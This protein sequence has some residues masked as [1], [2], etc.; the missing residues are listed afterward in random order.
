M[1]TEQRLAACRS[2]VAL[3]H[4]ALSEIVGDHGEALPEALRERAQ[5]ALDACEADATAR[6]AEVAAEGQ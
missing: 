4:V 6:L 3:L 1:T 5:A 2:Q